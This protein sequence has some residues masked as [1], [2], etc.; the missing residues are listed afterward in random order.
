MIN[1]VRSDPAARGAF[2]RARCLVYL[3]TDPGLLPGALCAGRRQCA[4]DARRASAC[5]HLT[6][7]ISASPTAAAD[8]WSAH[9]IRRGRRC[10]STNGRPRV[11]APMPAAFTTVGT[12]RN[13][14]NDVVSNGRPYYLVQ[15]P[16]LSR[17]ARRRAARRSADRAS[18]GSRIRVPTMIGR[19]AGGFTFRPVVPM[20]LD[21]DNY[22]RYI[23]VL[24]RRVHCRQRS[25]RRHALRMVQR[26][27][28][29]LSRRGPA[30]WSPSSPD[31]KIHS[32]RCRAARLC[33]DAVGA[34]E[35][36]RAVNADYP[37][38]ARPRANRALSISTRST[39]RRDRRRG[40]AVACQPM[41]P[42]THCS[43]CSGST[44]CRRL[45]QRLSSRAVV[46]ASLLWGGDRS[47]PS[48]LD[49][50]LARLR[51]GRGSAR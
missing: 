21:I 38:H 5:F 32:E 47:A 28:G 44:T 22:R 3:E 15:A 33:D 7:P 31:L 14:G 51:D 34:V 16:Q 19:S 48:A 39:P 41:L 1:L 37:R 26:S 12:W 27:D 2:R 4:A 23:S 11:P 36:F 45:A 25:L 29:L 35:A 24:A 49:S 20:S 17:D 10:C 13:N 43:R 9:G 50:D 30:R 8:R 42:L 46:V 6:P 18:N 40:G